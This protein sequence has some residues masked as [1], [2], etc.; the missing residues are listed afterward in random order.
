MAANAAIIRCQYMADP[1]DSYGNHYYCT[2]SGWTGPDS[3]KFC[4][5]SDQS[6]TA[7]EETTVQDDSSAGDG[8][9]D[10]LCNIVMGHRE[11]SN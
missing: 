10:G 4:A 2:E 1:C 5:P 8:D 7:K 9:D 3:P 6:N 11:C